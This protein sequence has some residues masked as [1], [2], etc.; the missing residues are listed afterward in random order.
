MRIPVSLVAVI[1]LSVTAHADVKR[2]VGGTMRLTRNIQPVTGNSSK[3]YVV[4]QAAGERLV[5]CVRPLV[6]NIKV[7]SKIAPGTRLIAGTAELRGDEGAA[8]HREG[9][10]VVYVVRGAG[11]AVLGNRRVSLEAGSVAFI[12]EGTSHRISSSGVAP[13]EYVWVLGPRSSAESFRQ[14]ATLGC[15]DGPA[16]TNV[17]PLPQSDP[18]PPTVAGG[19]TVGHGAVIV[20]PGE[21]ERLRY[22]EIPLVLTLKVESGI[23]PGARLRASAGAL[24][25]GEERGVHL[26]ADEVLYVVRGHGQAI[27][28]DETIAVQPGSIMFVPQDTPHG[29][30][31]PNDEPLEYFVVHSPQAS[32]AGFRRRAAVPGPHCSGHI[33]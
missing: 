12:P 2:E 22:C 21:G 4:A 16:S 11:H 19:D 5:Y 25:R 17:A 8:T 10:E 14:A 30:I 7:D 32:A 6:L 27:V 3:G 9:D 23:N 24:S 28:G 1:G 26:D 15:G 20:P 31:N 33:Q 29:L 18:P 13:L